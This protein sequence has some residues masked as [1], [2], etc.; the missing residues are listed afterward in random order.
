MTSLNRQQYH[1]IVSGCRVIKRVVFVFVVLYV[2]LFVDVA[3]CLYI[4]IINARPVVTT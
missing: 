4:L 2:S 1:G 3:V